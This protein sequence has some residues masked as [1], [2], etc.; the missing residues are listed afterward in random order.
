MKSAYELAME[1]LER[2]DPS[3]TAPLNE[4]QKQDLAEIDERFRAKK[5]EREIFLKQQLERERDSG[6]LEE[7][8]QIERQIRDE[9]ARLEEEREAAK[10]KVRSEK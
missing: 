6:N 4:A 5:A 9:M 2:E 3:S 8:A 7:V 10:D 1:R